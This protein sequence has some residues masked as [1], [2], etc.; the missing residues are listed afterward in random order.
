LLLLLRLALWRI[1]A[2]PHRTLRLED[3]AAA[4]TAGSAKHVSKVDRDFAVQ[5]IEIGLL[6]PKLINKELRKHLKA[7]LLSV[8]CLIPS[9]KFMHENLKYLKVGSDL[10]KRLLVGEQVSKGTLHCTLRA[11]WEERWKNKKKIPRDV[12]VEKPSG[13]Q[14]IKDV[15]VDTCWDLTYKQ[16]W[17]FVL[18]N[19]ADLAQALEDYL[20]RY[21]M[22]GIT[23]A[24]ETHQQKR[25]L[26]KQK[27][28][29]II[30]DCPNGNSVQIG[31]RLPVDVTLLIPYIYP[32]LLAYSITA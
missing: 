30:R 32:K 26:Q 25:D 10:L 8:R 21:S 18:R 6:F 7:S 1:R 31:T 9:I 15:S 23:K 29:K 20:Q 17:I 3:A 22:R 24:V 16:L 5:A 4:W 28:H 2:R 11:G 13:A 14:V 19:F 27:R 12:L